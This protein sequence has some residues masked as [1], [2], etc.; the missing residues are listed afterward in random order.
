MRALAN[1]VTAA[2][3]AVTL[4]AALA[5]AGCG[6]IPRTVHRGSGPVP[7]VEQ[8]RVVEAHVNLPGEGKIAHPIWYSGWFETAAPVDLALIREYC[9]P[10]DVATIE[11]HE[12][13]GVAM[14]TGRLYTPREVLFTCTTAGTTASAP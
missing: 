14:L 12:V 4:V 5:T 9:R 10:G 11:E 3:L 6:A 13:P 1:V 8:D 2:S 7:A